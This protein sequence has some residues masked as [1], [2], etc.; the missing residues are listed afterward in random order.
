MQRDFASKVELDDA[1]YA[2]G[3]TNTV[4]ALNEQAAAEIN[5]QVFAIPVN[6]DPT[7]DITAQKYAVSSN[8]ENKTELDSGMNPTGLG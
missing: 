3:V 6:G 8:S 7:R 5:R 2:F 1:M 4:T